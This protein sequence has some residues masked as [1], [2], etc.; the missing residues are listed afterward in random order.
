M[1]GERLQKEDVIAAIRRAAEELETRTITKRRFKEHTGLTESSL[2]RHFDNWSQAVVAAGLE[3]GSPR[4]TDDMLFRNMLE[5]FRKTDGM[6]TIQAF[7]RLSLI[8]IDVYRHRFGSWPHALLAFRQ[9]LEA[10]HEPF[11][12]LARLPRPGDPA[13]L[14]AA[15]RANAKA[16]KRWL[17]ARSR[18]ADFGP[19]LNFRGMLH[20]PV[21]EQGV[22]LLFGAV[23]EDLGFMVECVRIAYP[24]C[25]AKRR[26]DRKGEGWQRV[27]I[28]FEFRSSSFRDAGHDPAACDLVVCWIHDWPDCPLEVLSL[29]D[30]LGNLKRTETIQTAVAP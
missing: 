3:P 26:A 16:S 10:S 17:L 6:L 14:R 9:W 7:S 22:V 25:E 11:P 8:W 12:Q 30:A 29:R 24:D 5:T 1:K 18:S 23:C 19:L 4:Y 2:R 20:E 15:A 28:E 21:N 27:L 13:L